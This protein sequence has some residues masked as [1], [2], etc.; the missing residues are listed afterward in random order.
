MLIQFSVRNFK[1]FREKAVLNLVASNYDKD[2]REIENI[3]TDTEFNLRIVK[4]AV[5]YGANASGKSKFIEAL[6]F[7]RE[8]AI[9]S[10]KDSQKGDSIKVEP[11]KLEIESE[12]DSSEFEVIFIF[13]KEMFRYGF[14][15]TKDK[16]F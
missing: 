15:V 11:F 13:K 3:K 9:E 4:S 7:M 10:S 6:M 1:T 12:K 2:I 16:I 8:F 5:I 14:E